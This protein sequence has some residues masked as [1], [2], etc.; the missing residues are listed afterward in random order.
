MASREEIARSK[1]IVDGQPAEKAL[2]N[3]KNQA[4]NL[5]LEMNK[6]RKANDLA[7]FKEKER[8]LKGVN[9]EMRV[10]K[11]KATDVE[12]VLKKLNRATPK[13]LKAA[14]RSLNQQVNNLEQGTKE[15]IK[16]SE[17]LRK[18]SAKYKKVQG[19]IRGVS[20]AQTS[21]F[22]KA[23]NGFNK[24]FMMMA[25][26]SA[27]FFGLIQM[28][29]KATQAYN[30]FEE[31]LT[32]VYTLLSDEDMTAFGE[33]LEKGSLQVMKKYGKEVQD[34]N[35]ALFD[36]ISAGVPAGESIAF[37]DQAARLSV[38][39]VTELSTATDGMTTV[40]NAF[41]LGIEESA[42]V[43]DAFFAAQKEGKT[44]VA[45]LSQ[46]I[47]QVAPIAY[48]V[49]VSYQE[50]MSQMA[51][52]TKQGISTAEAST[53][54]KGTY[55]ALMKPSE[56]LANMF[57]NELGYSLTRTEM[58]SRGFAQVM[59]D[60]N[61]L[62]EKYPDSVADMIPNVRGVTAAFALS[63]QGF[64]EYNRILNSV[65][66]DT[67]ELSSLNKAFGKQE[68][69]NAHQLKV[70]KAEL[71]EQTILLGQKLAP[72]VTMAT[73]AM[74][75]FVKTLMGAI[76]FYKEN[77]ILINS[78][79]SAII[80]YGVAVKISNISS[81][82]YIR[83]LVK[84]RA[85]LRKVFATMKANPWAAAAALIAAAAVAIYRFTRR[86]KEATI[87]TEDITK[88]VANMNVKFNQEKKILDD[89]FEPLK[90]TTAG[91]EERKAAV[92][93]LKELYPEYL[94]NLDLEKASLED[95]EN[96]QR[97]ATEAL[98]NHM[99]AQMQKNLMDDKFSKQFE[100]QAKVVQNTI[101]NTA[102][103]LVSAGM[104][105]NKA[106]LES[107]KLVQD[108]YQS[109]E[110]FGSGQ[111]FFLQ[112]K[113]AIVDEQGNIT[114]GVKNEFLELYDV[115]T[116]LTE[117]LGLYQSYQKEID[118]GL[119]KIDAVINSMKKNT[120]GLSN[121][122]PTNDFNENGGGNYT[123]I[124]SADKT[125]KELDKVKEAYEKLEEELADISLSAQGKQI[126]AV[127][128]TYSKRRGILEEALDAE[129]ISQEE[130]DARIIQLESD[131]N[132]Q[133]AAINIKFQED[134]KEARFKHQ[135]ELLKNEIEAIDI[136]HEIDLLK[137]EGNLE[138][139]KEL[140]IKYL[141]EKRDLELL[142]EELTEEQKELIILKY[143]ARIKE[144]INST[145]EELIKQSIE[146][147]NRISELINYINEAVNGLQTAVSQYY[148]NMNLS[149]EQQHENKLKMM[150]EQGATEEELEEEKQRYDTAQ[151]KRDRDKAKWDK[152]FSVF[153]II[154]DTARGIVKALAE[155]NYAHAVMLG[156]VGAAQGALVA[157]KPLPEYAEG[158]Y[159]ATGKSGKKYKDLPYIGIPDTGV[160]TSPAIFAEE[161]PEL[162]VN[163]RD[164]QYLMANYPHVL[165][166]LQNIPQYADGK[167]T[168]TN[169]PE[170]PSMPNN[171]N[172][173]NKI[174]ALLANI[175]NNTA[176]G[177]TIKQA[178]DAMQ[179]VEDNYTEIANDFQA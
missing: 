112:N 19:E 137:F 30:E 125:Q 11:G 158:K 109:V 14:M 61:F 90:K 151:R 57:Q 123:P 162:I 142:N 66:N 47:G 157:A 52:L 20:N 167:T 32:N 27:G 153:S 59:E 3:L 131:K 38:G 60:L 92:D 35:K 130:Y 21:W 53:Y 128:D 101:E 111:Q 28:T 107:Q 143:Q 6:L 17:Q 95:I 124:A 134:E 23:A 139:K 56:T 81:M 45:E 96:L 160:Y 161:D 103:A 63:G 88:A 116:A 50:L 127:Y 73:S 76:D 159:D 55:T 104:D 140:L 86:T 4:K 24:Y 133:I 15:Y 62:M 70:K 97:R 39:G 168:N 87:E 113:K 135:A 16:K 146:N 119:N 34:V 1:V 37:L 26:V 48:N 106:L 7:G 40:L 172:F 85:S 2:L 43:A 110:K 152:A 49:G 29:R 51:A 144:V 165:S 69:T 42:A 149:A 175:S 83:T 179:D 93:K 18:V 176:K 72:A 164:T 129:V 22:S 163:G 117:G 122:M 67:G 98:Y 100:K 114:A 5:R 9:R 94:E 13:E 65:Q 77:K 75:Y 115:Q 166:F 89:L 64:E 147:I 31:T 170:Q 68:E 145:E 54:L 91:T 84:L 126:K 173:E 8:E 78:I 150:E 74:S 99:L 121:N 156:I 178:Y 169:T 46:N 132:T 118:S 105:E 58:Q 44:T 25:S 10:L 82:D 148:E 136:Q 155:Q 108:Y 71:R 80:A 33:E 174:I 41:N 177:M 102:D 138:Q 36:T 12:S 79:T 171:R 120:A 154:V 141:E